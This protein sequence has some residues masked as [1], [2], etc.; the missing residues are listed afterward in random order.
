MKKEAFKIQE[1]VVEFPE[2]VS[3]ELENSMLTIKGLKGEVKRDFNNPRIKLEKKG[4]SLVIL[5]SSKKHSKKDKCIMKTF[6]AHI[7]NMIEGTSKNYEA[8]LKICSSHFPMTVNLEGNL[9]KVKN[10]LGEKVPRK[11]KVYPDV[12]LNIDNNI[13]K[14]V[15]ANKESVGQTAANIESAMK[16]KKRD[17]R[18]FQDGI[19]ITKKPTVI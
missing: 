17:K 13:I 5:V 15:G 6:Y 10:F 2:G 4:D 16:I 19:W 12:K 8:E 11:A 18:I 9:L 3:F 14:I 7:K 1:R